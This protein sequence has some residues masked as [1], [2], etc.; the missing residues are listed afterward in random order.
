M[1][2][3]ILLSPAQV[4]FFVSASCSFVDELM[5]FSYERFSIGT[6]ST[7]SASSNPKMRE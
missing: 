6:G 2:M 4:S 3:V 1:P 5:N 7:A